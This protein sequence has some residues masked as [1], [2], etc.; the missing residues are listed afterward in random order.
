V[1][2]SGGRGRSGSSRAASGAGVAVAERPETAQSPQSIVQQMTSTE[3]NANF[4]MVAPDVD[5]ALRLAYRRRPIEERQQI[6][7]Q[8]IRLTR[9]GARERFFRT[10]LG[11]TLRTG[12][13][14]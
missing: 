14:P 2:G 4:D 5:R 13:I 3:V 11:G 7:D 10:V 1:A 6:L 9:P 12:E 8:G